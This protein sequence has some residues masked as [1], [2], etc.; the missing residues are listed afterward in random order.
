VLILGARGLARRLLCLRS[1][2][3]R[4]AS[5]ENDMQTLDNDDLV[6]ATG[7]TIRI[8]NIDPLPRPWPSPSPLPF[9]RPLPQPLPFPYPIPADP[10]LIASK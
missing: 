10:R 8:P 2:Q 3:S 6:T 7:G 4:R 1:R 5:Q 9:P